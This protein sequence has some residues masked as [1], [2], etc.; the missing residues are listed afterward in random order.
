MKHFRRYQIDTGTKR[1]IYYALSTSIVRNRCSI[2]SADIFVIRKFVDGDITKG[3][4]HEA[5]EGL[6]T[7]GIL[8][9]AQHSDE[10]TTK[11]KAGHLYSCY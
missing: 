8:K 10:D 9:K 2:I 7:K 3:K 4:D 11:D 1:T 6:M 5:L